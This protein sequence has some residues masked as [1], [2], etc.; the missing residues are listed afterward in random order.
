MGAER[1]LSQRIGETG[2]RAG[3]SAT[4]DQRVEGIAILS[5]DFDRLAANEG[6]P[7]RTVRGLAVRAKARRCCG[8]CS[9]AGAFRRDRHPDVLPPTFLVFFRGAERILWKLRV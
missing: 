1:R 8:C 3:R 4:A 6:E 9:G 2:L 5:Q 7:Q